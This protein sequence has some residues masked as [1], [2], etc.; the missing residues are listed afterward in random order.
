[1]ASADHGATVRQVHRASAPTL[2]QPGGAMWI[3][4]WEKRVHRWAMDRYLIAPGPDRIWH[5]MSSLDDWLGGLCDLLQRRGRSILLPHEP[6]YPPKDSALRLAT[7]SLALCLPSAHRANRCSSCSRCAGP[8]KRQPP[9]VDLALSQAGG[10][11]QETFSRN[12][13]PPVLCG[14]VRLSSL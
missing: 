12:L 7:V 11:A 13:V 10:S 8:R 3:E 1:M 6:R 9:R 14:K 2:A 5:V 4:R